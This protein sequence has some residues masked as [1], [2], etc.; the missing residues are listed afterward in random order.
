MRSLL[1]I[2]AVLKRHANVR[3]EHVARKGNAHAKVIVAPAVFA[4]ALM[5][6]AAQTAIVLVAN[7]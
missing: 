2:A 5:L 1:R 3:K 6:R 4:A 7:H